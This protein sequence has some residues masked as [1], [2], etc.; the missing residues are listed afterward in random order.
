MS[1]SQNTILIY[2]VK[3]IFLKKFNNDA[4]TKSGKYIFNTTLLKQLRY[5]IQSFVQIYFRAPY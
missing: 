4:I 5:Y 2:F 1:Q 3:K